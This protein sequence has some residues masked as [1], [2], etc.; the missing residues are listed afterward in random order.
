MFML[1]ISG[2]RT[3]HYTNPERWLLLQQTDYSPPF[4][5][6]GAVFI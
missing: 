5:S 2:D 1:S 3:T 4:P 6:H